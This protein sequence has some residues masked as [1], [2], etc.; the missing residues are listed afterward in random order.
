M[1]EDRR[2]VRVVVPDI[3]PLAL[4]SIFP[5][6]GR[7]D[8]CRCTSGKKYKRC[9]EAIDRAAWRAVA[10]KTREADAILDLL[11]A[12]PSNWPEY[13]PEPNP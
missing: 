12:L 4:E 5:T 3:D 6:P 10:K 9:H 13:N 8:P 2:V 11:R 7:N 1:I